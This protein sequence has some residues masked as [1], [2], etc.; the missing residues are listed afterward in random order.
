[1]AIKPFKQSPR[2]I[3]AA[4]RSEV[5]EAFRMQLTNLIVTW[6]NCEAWFVNIFARLM[7]VDYGRAEAVI[8]S[9]ASTRGRVD[10]VQRIAIMCVSDIGKLRSLNKICKEFKAVNTLRN[11]LV[12]AVYSTYGERD[13][14]SL[15]SFTHINFQRSNFDGTNFQETR[16]IDEKLIEEITLAARKAQKLSRR[17]H[18]WYDST[19]F[20]ISRRPR[21]KPLQLDL[22]HKSKS[23]HRRR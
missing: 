7:R 5:D 2:E 12:H 4:D 23:R 21:D 10:L 16:E 9:I 13:Y 1:M 6:G 20:L 17:L 14:N 11:T 3:L 22:I 8:R 19:H 18:Y 15:R